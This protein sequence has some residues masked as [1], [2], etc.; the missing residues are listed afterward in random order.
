[1]LNA[2]SKLFAAKAPTTEIAGMLLT[3]EEA[4][5]LIRTCSSLKQVLNV[6]L[7]EI[8]RFPV[9]PPSQMSG[10]IR[11]TGSRHLKVQSYISSI[12]LDTQN[13]TQVWT[14]AFVGAQ[15]ALEK[16]IVSINRRARVSGWEITAQQCWPAV[17]ETYAWLLPVVVKLQIELQEALERKELWSSASGTD[18]E[19]QELA[20]SQTS[21]TRVSFAGEVKVREYRVGEAIGE[22]DKG[23]YCMK[24][25]G[26]KKKTKRCFKGKKVKCNVEYQVEQNKD[27]EDA[28]MEV[29]DD[30]KETAG[31]FRD[32]E[33]KY[34]GMPGSFPQEPL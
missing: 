29:V 22:G 12:V 23:S 11:M 21:F 19:Q 2:V 9:I 4:T 1:M 6:Q 13:S 3:I 8:G 32:E 15:V 17:A 16:K 31:N 20:V 28:M 26:D 10:K 18:Q 34:E 33:A 27:K 14:H 7:H 24:L 25:T 30:R 5:Q